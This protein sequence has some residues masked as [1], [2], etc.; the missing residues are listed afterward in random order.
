MIG[1]KDIGHGILQG[2]GLHLLLLYSE[3]VIMILVDRLKTQG[4]LAK[5]RLE[6]TRCWRFYRTKFHDAIALLEFPG[7][8]NKGR[9]GV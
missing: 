5:K 1:N 4:F 6:M 9:L 8:K 2:T 7:M 3:I